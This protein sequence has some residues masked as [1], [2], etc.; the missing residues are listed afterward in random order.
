MRKRPAA[1][2]AVTI[3]AFNRLA[4]RKTDGKG[5]HVVPLTGDE[6]LIYWSRRISLAI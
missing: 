6:C 3:A 2:S 1:R 5:I 4:L